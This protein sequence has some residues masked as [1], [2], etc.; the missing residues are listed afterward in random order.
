MYTELE[1]L[2][3]GLQILFLT[4]IIQYYLLRFH[5]TQDLNMTKESLPF[6]LYEGMDISSTCAHVDL[7]QCTPNVVHF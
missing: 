3:I 7:N 1:V 2:T 6:R 4:L 5:E